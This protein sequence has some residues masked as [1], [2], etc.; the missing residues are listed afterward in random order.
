MR[1]SNCLVT[2]HED[3]V[4]F[5]LRIS[6]AE[7]AETKALFIKKGFIDSAWNLLNWEKRQFTSDTSNARVA[8]HRA[9]KKESKKE[10]CNGVVTLQ[11]QEANGLDTDTDTDTEVVS[12]PSARSIA[13]GSRLA[14][15]WKP[16]EELREWATSERPDLE[17]KSTIDSFVDFWKSKSGKDAT[18]LDWDAT[19]RNWVRSQR[20]QFKTV[21]PPQGVANLAGVI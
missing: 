14:A 7:L 12:A 5:Q 3:E 11:K 4:A 2:L 16:S 6:D 17:V 9:L 1:C 21:K 19:F 10:P 18:K 15:D 8:K 20:Q 13:K